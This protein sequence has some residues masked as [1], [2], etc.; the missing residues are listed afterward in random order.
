MFNDIVE[1]KSRLTLK[2]LE[3]PDRARCCGNGSHDIRSINP[4][5]ILQLKGKLNHH[6]STSDWLAIVTLW[7]V[8]KS[9]EPLKEQPENLIGNTIAE[10]RSLEDLSGVVGTFFIFPHLYIKK[11]GVYRLCFRLV[12]IFSPDRVELLPESNLLDT[13]YSNPFRVYTPRHYPGKSKP[14]MLMR[15][16]AKQTIDLKA[17]NL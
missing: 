1:S 17:R 5:P 15:F 14:S 8:D 12:R 6:E 16:L 9:N 3:H 2:L 10:S 11:E 7:S 4:T 13:I